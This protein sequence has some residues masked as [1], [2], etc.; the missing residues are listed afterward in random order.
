[1]ATRSAT[2]L[3]T[4]LVALLGAA[5][6]A[7]TPRADEHSSVVTPSFVPAADPTP[8]VTGT[9]GAAEAGA[10][11]GRG[12]GSGPAGGTGASAGGS[13]AGAA[14]T[15]SERPASDAGGACRHLT[16][17]RVRQVLGIEFQV[18]AAG[19]T[20]TTSQTCVLQEVAEPDS[21]LL[22]TITPAVGVDATAFRDSYVP[23]GGGTLDGV[24]KAAY[25]VVVRAPGSSAPR[26]EIG[27]LS[28]SGR[29]LTLA[30]TLAAGE[31]PNLT[32]QVVARLA[33]LAGDVDN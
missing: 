18:A 19:G 9:P 10:G 15:V 6:C 22:L 27:W 3:A 5:G 31:D 28:G 26:V 29:V 8:A 1:M 12:A 16:F 4:V 21:D 30:H 32:R 11:S 25:S 7:A 24:G 33:R 20:V 2:M 14:P 23:S 13:S 17:A